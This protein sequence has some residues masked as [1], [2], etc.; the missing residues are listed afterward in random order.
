[1]IV[2]SAASLTIRQLVEL[3]QPPVSINAPTGIGAVDGANPFGGI[4]GSILGESPEAQKERLDEAAKGANDLTNLVRRKKPG[5]D[6]T[7]AWT[8]ETSATSSGKR[9]LDAADESED[10]SRGKKAKSEGV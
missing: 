3:R 5:H 8:N 7:G 10:L 6:D 1:V 2:T 9:K 4:L